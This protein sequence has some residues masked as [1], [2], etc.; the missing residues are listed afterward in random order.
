MMPDFHVAETRWII[1]KRRFAEKKRGESIYSPIFESSSFSQAKWF[2]KLYPRGYG[3]AE[4]DAV[5][6]YLYCDSP[7][8]VNARYEIRLENCANFDATVKCC[9]STTFHRNVSNSGRKMFA[10][11]DTVMKTNEGFFNNGALLFTCRI[12]FE[13]LPTLSSSPLSTSVFSRFPFRNI[14]NQTQH[15]RQDC[16]IIVKNNNQIPVSSAVLSKHSP[17]FKEMFEAQ[18]SKKKLYIDDFDVKLIQK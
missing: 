17:V 7:Q 4:G 18:K 10:L 16:Q 13:P 11:Y 5:S 3:T 6:V 9:I 14:T 15:S 2:L 8:H 12:E 1:F